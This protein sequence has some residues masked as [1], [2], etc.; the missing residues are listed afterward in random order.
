MLKLG[1]KSHTLPSETL[2]FATTTSALASRTMFPV[3]VAARTGD[4]DVT[5]T[6][7]ISMVHVPGSE[8]IRRKNS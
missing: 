1:L 3:A 4:T 6:L 8:R 5:S 7:S 2:M